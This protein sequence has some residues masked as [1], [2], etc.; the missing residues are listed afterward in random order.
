[1]P[2]SFKYGAEALALMGIA[3]GLI[4]WVG[5]TLRSLI[6]SDT[7]LESA[8]LQ[9][10]ASHTPLASADALVRQG[11]ISAAQVERMSPREREFLVATAG[12]Q[13]KAASTRGASS[14]PLTPAATDVVANATRVSRE[15]SLTPPRLHLITPA[16]PPLGMVVHCPG[17]GAPVDR[18]A[19]QRTGNTTCARCRRP[20]SAH[21]QRG[22]V[23]VIVEETPE[24]AAHRRRM[25][26]RNGDS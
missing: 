12:P 6:S 21:I 26:D 4:K 19:L 17:C 9:G 20:V 14:R 25:D 5:R 24:E 3:Y 23:T 13:L 2:A 22:R 1:M 16:R 15:R 8:R 18:D 10:L 11:L 7:S